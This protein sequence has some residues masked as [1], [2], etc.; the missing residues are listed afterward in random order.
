T[1]RNFRI[2]E[3]RQKRIAIVGSEQE[4]KRV[5][6][7]LKESQIDANIIGNI[8][9]GTTDSRS[10]N[11][12]GELRQLREV[13]QIYG[14]D[15]LIFCGKDLS[16]SEIM[17]W[18]VQTNN[19]AIEYKILPENSEYI[20]GSNSK[21]TQGDYYTLNIELNLFKKS[22]R[23]NKRVLDLGLSVLFLLLSPLLIW[24]VEHK[25]GFIRNCFGVLLGRYSWVGIQENQPAAIQQHR[26]VLSPADK[27]DIS[28]LNEQTVRRL[29]VLYAK[30]YT[31]LTDLEIIWKAFRHLGR[32]VR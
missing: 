18:M 8:G 21:N 26:A 23:R 30:E 14:L 12:L 1:Y 31:P 3:K 19:Q 15:E 5:T 22:Q 11:Y 29:E 16:S 28:T 17:E 25:G 4:S 32:N 27:F 20:I 10:E 6:R 24:G 7:L 13:V 2:G 9:V